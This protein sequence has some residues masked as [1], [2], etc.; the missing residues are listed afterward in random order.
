MP[1][2]VLG[3]V[4]GAD[5]FCLTAEPV[6]CIMFGLDGERG[7]ALGATAGAP[8]ALDGRAVRFGATGGALMA[9]ACGVS[10]LIT[11]FGSGTG[12]VLVFGATTGFLAG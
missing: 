7:A 6:R 9:G 12:A 4:V 3:S 8:T 5:T 10:V 1:M 11:G 2:S